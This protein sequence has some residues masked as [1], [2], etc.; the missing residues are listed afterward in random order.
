MSSADTL[1]EGSIPRQKVSQV[2]VEA[3][4]NDAAKNKIVEIVA[5]PDAPELSWNKLFAQVN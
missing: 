5:K 4:V 1:F 3:L 2:C